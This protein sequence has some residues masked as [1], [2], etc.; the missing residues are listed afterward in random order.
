MSALDEA[1]EAVYRYRRPEPWCWEV[2]VKAVCGD[3]HT[4]WAA[5]HAVF[6]AD[7][8]VAAHA[9]LI[10]E[11]LGHGSAYTDR[12][13]TLALAGMGDLRALPA[14]QRVADDN[15]LPSDRPRARILAVLPAAELLPVVL[16]VLRQ[17]PEQHDS[18]TALLELLALWGQASEPAVSEMI[19]FLGTADPYDAL[20]VLGRIGPPAAAAADRLAAYA[21]GRD[22]GARRPHTRVAAWAHW[23]VTG[24]P[25]LALDVCGTAVRSGTASHGLPFLADLGPLAAAHTDAVRRL[26]ESPGAWTRTYAAHAYWRITGDPGP[27]IPVLLAEA[28]P[29]WAGDPAMPVR[30]AVRILGKIGA[31]AVSAAPL[32]RRILAQEERLSR[33]W[34]GVRILADQAYVRTLTEALEGIDGK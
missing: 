24:D 1:T 7:G 28:D 31:P 2:V 8:A 22:P 17:N 23:K 14:L 21:T 6:Q 25:T 26:M 20:R 9:D 32:L 4:S 15:R 33:P 11:S 10:A 30:E 13:L 27:A 16:P 5:D 19:R 12:L 29:A 34:R 18:T 3:A